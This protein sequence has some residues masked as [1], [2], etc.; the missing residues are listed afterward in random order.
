[1]SIFASVGSGNIEAACDMKKKSEKPIG[2]WANGMDTSD[3]EPMG[4]VPK[5]FYKL[6][7]CLDN[8]RVYVLRIAKPQFLDEVAQFVQD[9]KLKREIYENIRGRIFQGHHSSSIIINEVTG[10]F[11]FARSSIL[12]GIATAKMY[13]DS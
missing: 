8:E 12:Y 6:M 5:F 1:M 13:I 7:L 10:I 4:A 3:I 9:P 2:P 11:K